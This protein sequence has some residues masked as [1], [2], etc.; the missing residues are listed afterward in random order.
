MTKIVFVCHGNICRSPMA[1]YIFKYLI[2]KKNMSEDFDISSAATSSEALRR[3][4][5]KEAKAE[6]DKHG[7]PY[8]KFE[9]RQISYPIYRDADYVICMEEY[10]IINLKRFLL[11]RK[12]D[13]VKLLLDF[14]AEPK[15]VDDPW[16]SG[17]FV[18]AYNEIYKGCT[19]LLEYLVNKV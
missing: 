16:Y 19:A 7:I 13:K 11:L 8:S 12:T 15:D 17:D 14:T 9:S 5:H 3:D 6:L 1:E 2:S 4:M 18:T 10:N